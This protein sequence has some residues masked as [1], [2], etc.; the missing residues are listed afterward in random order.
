MPSIPAN[1]PLGY[2]GVILILGG[3]VLIFVGLDVVRLD[4]VIIL[5]GRKT[6]GLGIVLVGFGLLFLFPE[7]RDIVIPPPPAGNVTIAL[8]NQDCKVQ[9]YYIDDKLIVTVNPDSTTIFETNTG[10]HWVQACSP[11]KTTCGGLNKV[12]WTSNTRRYIYRS[13]SC[14]ITITLIN[15][16]CKAQDYYV[17]EEL[18]VSVDGA[19]TTK[20]EITPGEHRVK[21]C[22][23]GSNVCTGSNQVTW[24]EATTRYIYSGASCK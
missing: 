24:S 16:Y 6:W 9:D 14:P 15:E 2:I 7:M 20:F 5:P 10:E 12:N 22:A 3:F 21:A 13:S 1:S 19:T 8:E 4:K 23:P 18:V 17:D 11:G